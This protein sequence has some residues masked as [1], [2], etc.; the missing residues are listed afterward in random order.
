MNQGPFITKNLRI[1]VML[2]SRLRN[3]F[4]ADNSELNRTAYAKQRNKCTSMIRQAK[5][6]FYGNLNPSIVS[7]NKLFWKTV[8]P[9]FSDKTISSQKIILIDS[10]VIVNDDQNVS[11]LFS[12]FFNDAVKN[13]DINMNQNLISSDII[14][15]ADPISLTINKYKNHPSIINICESNVENEDCFFFSHCTLDDIYIKKY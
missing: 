14:K 9:L 12:D 11:E 3:T 4:I 8:K 1:E 6:S 5:K 2:R 7:D 15:E 13:L 10:S